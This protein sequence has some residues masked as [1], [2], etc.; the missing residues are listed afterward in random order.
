MNL[1]E[2]A[3]DSFVLL[4]SYWSVEQALNFMRG[5]DA[6]HVIVEREEGNQMYYYLFSQQSA[7][8]LL[9]S[10]DPRVTIHVALDLHEY[11]SVAALDGSAS[12]DDAPDRVVVLDG[13]EVVGFFDATEPTSFGTSK[14][15]GGFRDRFEAFPS[16]TAPDQVKSDE[17]F[18]IFVG[19]SG[20]SDPELAP[21][22]RMIFENIEPGDE[23]L[24]VLIGDGVDFDRNSDQLPFREN[25]QVRF[26]CRPKP[27]FVEAA[28]TAQYQHRQQ[29]IGTAQRRIVIFRP[30]AHETPV[31]Q[32]K[33]ANP[34]RLELPSPERYVDLTVTITYSINGELQWRFTAPKPRIETKD[35]ILK[36]LQGAKEFAADLIRELKSQEHTGELAAN[37]LETKG[38]EVFRLMPPEFMEA[39]KSVSDAIGRT[40][41]LLLLT[42]EAYIPWEIAYLPQALDPA[43]PRFLAA[44]TQMGRWLND[45]NVM[46]PPAVK[47]DVRKL[48]AVASKYGLGTSQRELPEALAERDLLV[49]DWKAAAIEAKK[50]DINSLFSGTMAS[51]HLIHFAVHGISDPAANHQALLLAD[52]SEIPASGMMGSFNCG[53]EPR[54]V[55]VLLNACQVGTAGASLGQAAG[56]PGTLVKGGVLGFIAP[57]WEVDD[58]LAF[59]FAADFYKE[60]FTEGKPV[61]TVLQKQRMA[62]DR[63][64]ST[65]PLAYIYYGHP[66]LRLTYAIN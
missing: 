3:F 10:T 26:R 27:G 35:P 51:G 33:I 5:I 29:I 60:T 28:V 21:S 14:L 47:V 66:A 19:F 65:T 17:S 15:R 55:F 48:T 2:V 32:D 59:N 24:I 45:Q 57:L 1:S 42:N 53:E 4:Q 7:L 23:C 61:G 37:I 22:G 38:Q 16:L 13:G 52:N 30:G 25:A 36:P 64:G 46:L 40:P 49:K 41:T 50:P 43:A 39:L 18:D 58:K 44:Q 6:S 54:F 62:Y 8:A 11:T 31:P 63:A 56:F 12:A 9:H 34:C 20:D